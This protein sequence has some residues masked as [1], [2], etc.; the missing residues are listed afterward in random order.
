MGGAGHR[1]WVLSELNNADKHRLLLAVGSIPWSRKL[2]AYVIGVMQE[3]ERRTPEGHPLKGR[4][5]TAV[6]IHFGAPGEMCPLKAGD[7][8]F[9]DVPDAE[10]NENLD[11][12]FKVAFNEPGIIEGEPLIETLH[13]FTK[14]VGDI[15][16]QIV[17][18]L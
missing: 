8:L 5:Y 16:A 13:Q 6:D 4:D 9:V 3:V 18:L 2:S 10:M 12:R 15:V 14:L 1:L 7:E 17:R 11:F